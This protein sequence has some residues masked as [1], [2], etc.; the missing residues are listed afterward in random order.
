MFGSKKKKKGK[1]NN[2]LMYD[3]M[4]KNPNKSKV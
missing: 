3:F 1:E 2:F 4:V